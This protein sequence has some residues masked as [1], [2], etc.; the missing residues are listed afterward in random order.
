[1]IRFFVSFLMVFGFAFAQNSGV[2]RDTDDFTGETSCMQSIR[3][4]DYA[5]VLANFNEDPD[6]VS[7]F[8]FI[9]DN[10]E[11]PFTPFG[12]S[13]TESVMVKY[14]GEIRDLEYFSV[15]TSVL[16]NGNLE[17]IVLLPMSASYMQSILFSEGPVDVRLDGDNYNFDFRFSE[18]TRLL[19]RTEFF[20][21]CL[22]SGVSG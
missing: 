19:F 17:Q 3:E 2:Q 4:D 11:V 13:S 5:I 10:Y 20:M 14:E 7:W 6:S 21:E 16:R 22:P 18:E 15:D 9:E 8:I 12:S 1:M